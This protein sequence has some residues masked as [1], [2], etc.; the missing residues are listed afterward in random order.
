MKLIKILFLFT[1]LF[2]EET[3]E[4]YIGNTFESICTTPRYT[5]MG[6]AGNSNDNGAS[7]LFFNPA[8][9]SQTNG[10]EVIFGDTRETQLL[11]GRFGDISYKH[12]AISTSSENIPF[13][14]IDF[15]L[16]G[17]IGF[18]Y[19]NVKHIITH[20]ELMNYTGDY[21]Y[22]SLVASFVLSASYRFVNLGTKWKYL[23]QDFGYQNIIIDN[24]EHLSPIWSGMSLQYNLNNKWSLGLVYE[25]DLY[26]G[27][28]DL[29]PKQVN[30]GMGYES[31]MLNFNIDII[32]NEYWP[33]QLNSGFE[34]VF[35]SLGIV[36]IPLRMGLS[37][38][39]L[40]EN[41]DIDIT[42]NIKTAFGFGI[43]Y[44]EKYIIDFALSQLV[45]P[46]FINPY[47]RLGVIGVSVNF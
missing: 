11:G 28:Y 45:N 29:I 34:I 1:I 4:I 18:Q 31:N 16:G 44:K 25:K 41:K 22:T 10:F 7:S 43:N 19:F 23:R 33:A 36:K 21:S 6:N 27:E 20:D 5:A 47:S 15:K 38:V 42:N 8:G 2:S 14:P 26:I 17:G 35:N 40:E 37:G 46:S 39:I 24:K 9:V 12:L 13:F 3:S 32:S 30:I